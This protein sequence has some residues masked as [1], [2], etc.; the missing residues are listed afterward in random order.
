MTWSTK[1]L[2][3]ICQIKP[4]KREAGDQLNGNDIVSFV[5]ME[6]LCILTK[7][8][9]PKK[10][11][12]LKDV[13][14][15]YT[16]FAN[17]DVLLA[18]ITPC[19]ENGKIGIA[20]NLKNGIGFGSS[21]FFVFRSNGEILPDYLYYFLSRNEV[22]EQGEKVMTGAVG[23][24]R[25]P[26]DFIENLEIS[27]PKSLPTQRRIV[28]VLDDVFAQIDKAKQNAQ[29]N[30]QN[31]RE[32]FESYLQSVFEKVGDGWETCNLED[33]ITFIDY[34]GKTPKKTKQGMRLITAKNVKNGFIRTKPEE[35]VD[36]Q[37]YDTWMTRGIP[38]KGD[39]LFTSEAPLANVAQLDTD[40]KV[41]FAQRI[42]ILQPQTNKLDQAFLKYL[43][44]SQP[45]RQRILDKGT[46]ATVQGIKARLLKKIE[47]YFP[48]SLHA[49]R[50]IVKKLDALSAQTK[51]LEAI[52][53]QKLA[54]L[55]ELKQSVLK[56]AFSGDLC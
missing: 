13:S 41:V 8:F 56:K 22:R 30:L 34:R 47:I 6:D 39:I 25:V 49:Q 36:P 24:K 3:E 40:K 17:G 43:L 45:I 26:K 4:P 12:Q 54:D 21:E 19:F 38:R 28:K 32:L 23:H 16:Y 37:I 35:F 53:R 52:Y 46:G 29:K 51:K 7:E 11:R 5:P 10:E 33:Y 9:I 15:S 14:G 44:L 55:D 50:T 1:K 42:I 48:K 20:K 18:K 27:F 31:A 2:G